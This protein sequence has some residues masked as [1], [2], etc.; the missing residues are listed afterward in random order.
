MN[1]DCNYLCGAKARTLPVIILMFLSLT[2]ATN[3][4]VALMDIHSLTRDAVSDINISYNFGFVEEDFRGNLRPNTTVTNSSVLTKYLF[5]T[6]EEP[7]ITSSVS[8]LWIIAVQWFTFELTSIIFFK[9]NLGRFFPGIFRYFTFISSLFFF[10][11]RTQIFVDAFDCTTT[12]SGLEINISEEDEIVESPPAPRSKSVD[13]FQYLD[14]NSPYNVGVRRAKQEYR[15]KRKIQDN[16]ATTEKRIKLTNDRRDRRSFEELSIRQIDRSQRYSLFRTESGIMD[17]LP[18]EAPWAMFLY[19]AIATLFSDEDIDTKVYMIQSG[20]YSLADMTPEQ[21]VV[22]SVVL[23]II[24]YASKERTESYDL[25]THL[26]ALEDALRAEI[27][28]YDVYRLV[29]LINDFHSL[30]NICLKAKNVTTII[31]VAGNI[32]DKHTDDIYKNKQ[33]LNAI[34]LTAPAFDM[35]MKKQGVFSTEAALGDIADQIDDFGTAPLFK[36]I[37]NLYSSMAAMHYLPDDLSSF[38]QDRFGMSECGSGASAYK[39]IFTSSLRI[40][41]ELEEFI[42]GNKSLQDLI[43]GN[44]DLANVMDASKDIIANRHRT[45]IGQERDGYI[46]ATLYLKDVINNISLLETLMNRVKKNSRTKDACRSLLVT[47]KVIEEEVNTSIM[48]AR[49]DPPFSMALIGPPGIGKGN[50]MTMFFATLANVDKIKFSQDLI[51]AVPQ[52]Y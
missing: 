15:R 12:E 4:T 41:D 37:K 21:D 26:Q 22:L 42:R 45:Y 24:L 36:H 5:P 35:W 9:R 19:D 28:K 13:P 27:A 11:K 18:N 23:K 48:A 1:N 17:M 16:I 49:R 30:F 3:N 32:F 44:R 43:F 33:F 2:Y 46:D 14:P 51:F 10:V 39:T 40:C 50:L 29:M 8:Y 47:L 34:K 20:L 38:L 31:K 7:P 25:D 6:C 52:T